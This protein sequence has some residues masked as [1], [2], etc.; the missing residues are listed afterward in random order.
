[1]ADAT[2]S[3]SVEGNFMW[4][5]L[6][7]PAP[8][9]K[10]AFLLVFAFLKQKPRPCICFR[11]SRP[12]E[13]HKAFAATFFKF[14]LASIHDSKKYLKRYDKPLGSWDPQKCDNIF[15]VKV[16]PPLISL[17]IYEPV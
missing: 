14:N 3:K 11:L 16:S 13:K 9:A 6:P 5:R 15:G 4:V 1:M 7:P 2:D 12:N 8:S 17:K 10:T